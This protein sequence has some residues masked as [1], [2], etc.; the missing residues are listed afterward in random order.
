MAKQSYMYQIG[1]R[2]ITYNAQSGTISSIVH[3]EDGGSFLLVKLD[4]M[5]GEYAYDFS[6]VTRLAKVRSNHR[7]KAE[8]V[9][10]RC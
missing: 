9:L 2:V 6:E 1:E 7:T 3:D 4:H 10:S 8:P 5:T